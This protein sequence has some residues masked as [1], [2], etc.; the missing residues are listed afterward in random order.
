MIDKCVG[1][2]DLNLD[3]LYQEN[4]GL[5]YFFAKR[6]YGQLEKDPA[7]DVD[8]LIQQGFFGLVRAAKTYN[9]NL[10]VT[11]A[12]WASFHIRR[13]MRLIVGLH[14]SKIRP[15]IGAVSLD[16]PLTDGDDF[17]LMDTLEDESAP[18][19]FLSVEEK[20]LCAKVRERVE[21][22]GNE[23]QRFA[24]WET[25]IKGRDQASVG[26]DLGVSGARV[27]QLVQEGYKALRLDPELRELARIELETRF[28]AH[29]GVRAFNVDWMSVT[30]AAAI[31]RIEQ[32]EKL[33][34]FEA[35][36]NKTRRGKCETNRLDTENAGSLESDSRR[37]RAAGGDSPAEIALRP[38]GEDS[39]AGGG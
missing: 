20:Q 6:Y 24:V 1:G 9:E 33:N 17:S 15:E 31:W 38:A 23:K 18:E 7:V 22:L 11:F 10:D 8:D 14:G 32:K 39:Q 28:H 25:S 36:R 5:L 12:H 34:R 27:G 13:E 3:T 16:A 30:E 21:A 19:A 29:K 37:D 2:A 4:K 35:I 26:D